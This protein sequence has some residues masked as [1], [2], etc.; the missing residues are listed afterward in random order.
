MHEGWK[1][2]K[3]QRRVFTA[4]TPAAA[5]KKREDWLDRRRD[6]FVMPRGRPPTVAEWM[7]YWLGN[8]AKDKVQP[9]T[10]EGYR[11]YVERRI[12]PYFEGVPL[13][14]LNEEMIEG[15]HRYLGKD[16][17]AAS[18]VQIHRIM[19][20]AL[21]VAVVRGRIPRNPCSNVTPP[22]I[23]RDEPQ[24]P[25]T[26]ESRPDRGAVP[27]VGQRREVAARDRDRCPAG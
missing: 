1:D 10:W 9:T 7:S 20:R 13:P 5:M 21:K 18:I 4:T 3:R 22:A 15:F 16:L 6:G 19:A 11:S 2:G 12:C 25:T 8:I 27:D 14:E 24:P 23:D 17:A 26:S